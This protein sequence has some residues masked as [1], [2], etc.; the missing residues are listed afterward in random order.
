MS[1]LTVTEKRALERRFGMSTGYVLGFSNRTFSD[2]MI[3]TVRIDPYDS[4][5]DSHG[6]SKANRLRAVWQVEPN[7]IVGRVTMEML[8]AC[9]DTSPEHE[10]CVRIATRLVASAPVDLDALAPESG[11]D[12]EMLVREVQASIGRNE[13]EA[14]LDRL[15]TYTVKFFRTVATARG[16]S[17]DREKPLHSV[18]GEYVKVLK[19]AGIIE[20][21]MT[22]RILRSTISILEAFNR[23]RNDRSLAHDNKPLGYDESLLVFNHVCG[24]IRFVRSIED[25][26]RVRVEAQARAKQ[27]DGSNPYAGPF[28]SGSPDDDIPF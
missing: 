3:D 8:A 16:I 4:K 26:D 19:A 14:G 27:P 1:D 23:I 22:E 13:P 28:D 20:S 5:Y 2:F 11:L 10:Q 21:D 18:V 25:R 17:V 15:H 12:F 24:V 6:D 9:T 7:H